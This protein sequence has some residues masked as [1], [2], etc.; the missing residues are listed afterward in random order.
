MSRFVFLALG[1]ALSPVHANSIKAKL[2]SGSLARVADAKL[3]LNFQGKGSSLAYDAGVIT[4]AYKEITA[5]GDNK[6]VISANSGGS[7]LAVYFTCRGINDVSVGDIRKILVEGSD[8][9]KA[10]VEELRK[11]PENIMKKIGSMSKGI[12]PAIDLKNLDPYIEAALGID[13]IKD[14]DKA[15]CQS[16]IPFVIV[17]G[18]Y[19]VVDSKHPDMKLEFKPTDLLDPDAGKK[20]LALKSRDEKEFDKDNFGVSWKESTFKF[21]Q[22]KVKTAAGLAE[23]QKDH[24]NLQLGSSKYIGKSCTY[25][26]SPEMYEVLALVPN[27]ERLCDVRLVDSPLGMA[28]AIRASAAEPTYFPPVEEPEPVKLLTSDGKAGELGTTLKRQ[29]WGGF[30]MPMVAQDIRRSLPHLTVVGTGWTRFDAAANS[31][32]KALVLIDSAQ[33]SNLSEYW[34][35]IAIVP[36]KATQS[37][38]IVRKLTPNEE[39]EQGRLRFIDCIDR[40][41]KAAKQRCLP[42][43]VLVPKHKVVAKSALESGPDVVGTKLK[44]QRGLGDLIKR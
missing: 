11:G 28:T 44:G 18:N 3:L 15:K 29:Y 20:P 9:V 42:D 16:K 38:I 8:K 34:A 26:A 13:D 19:E 30:V 10:S 25:F 12:V 37:S 6:V 31:I 39:F 36:T 40:D 22:E 17:A 23:F 4:E 35:D 41:R 32:L 7:I 1:L 2:D 14:L 27:E 24:P 43:T 21:F 5:L 33:V